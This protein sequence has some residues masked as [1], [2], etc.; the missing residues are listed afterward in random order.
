[1]K[2]LRTQKD[3]IDGVERIYENIHDE[4]EKGLTAICLE[5]YLG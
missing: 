5:E 4:E 2:I 1:M 3:D